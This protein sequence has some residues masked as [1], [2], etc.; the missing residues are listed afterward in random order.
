MSKFGNISIGFFSTSGS[1]G[2]GGGLTFEQCVGYGNSATTPMLFESDSGNVEISYDLLRLRDNPL[3]TPDNIIDIQKD[4]ILCKSVPLD[5]ITQIGKNVFYGTIAISQVSGGSVYIEY[6]DLFYQTL[7]LPSC[8]GRLELNLTQFEDNIDLTN[9][10]YTIN[11]TQSR[12]YNLVSS[13]IN[14]E[15]NNIT[16]DFPEGL[17]MY[18]FISN[19]VG[20]G[21]IIFVGANGTNVYGLTNAQ[22]F[23]GLVIIN[24]TNGA[25]WIGI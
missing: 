12:S 24:R 4:K 2:G 23:A 10:G 8:N 3:G 22:Y 11:A 6:S 17:T 19:S 9:S 1:G 25:Y 20:S 13:D 5:R 7:Y 16:L 14:S 21:N 18:I 15:G